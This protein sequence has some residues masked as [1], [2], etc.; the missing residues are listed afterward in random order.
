VFLYNYLYCREA[1]LI[2]L[3]EKLD[4]PTLSILLNSGDA[5]IFCGCRG[6]RYVRIDGVTIGDRSVPNS[7]CYG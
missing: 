6:V 2:H 4:S 1:L 5:M 3:I 7:R